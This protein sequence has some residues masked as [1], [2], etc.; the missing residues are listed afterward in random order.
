MTERDEKRLRK[1]D[2]C[3][4]MLGKLDLVVTRIRT[5]QPVGSV[6][7]VVEDELDEDYEA[8][9]DMTYDLLK[10]L[11]EPVDTLFKSLKP[12][13]WLKGR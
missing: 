3:N 12:V 6:R 4:L 5:L 1:N 9:E 2:M 8:F 7:H 11:E 13:P 10:D